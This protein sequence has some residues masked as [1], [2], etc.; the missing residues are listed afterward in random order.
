MRHLWNYMRLFVLLVLLRRAQESLAYRIRR[1]KRKLRGWRRHSTLP[2]R[3]PDKRDIAGESGIDQ[4][5]LP[6]SPSLF[7]RRSA[8][9][10]WRGRCKF[11]NIRQA[12]TFFDLS[13]LINSHIKAVAA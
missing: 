7:G 2:C 11:G 6:A 4:E 5:D 3:T 8:R 12:Q 10:G 13:D 9:F 1:E